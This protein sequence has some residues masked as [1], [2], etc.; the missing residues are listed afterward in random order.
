[1]IAPYQVAVAEQLDRWLQV[2]ASITI[3]ALIALRGVADEHRLREVSLAERLEEVRGFVRDP[4]KFGGHGAMAAGVLLLAATVN[5]VVLWDFLE[6]F[7]WPASITMLADAALVSVE[8][9][10]TAFVGRGIGA[11]V[12][13]RPG[14]FDLERRERQQTLAFTVVFGLVAAGLVLV[15]ALARSSVLWALAGMAGAG[16]GTW[17]GV[18]AYEAKFHIQRD[19]LERKL[20]RQRRKRSKAEE[21]VERAMAFTR[22]TGRWLRDESRRILTRGDQAFVRAYRDEH[23]HEDDVQVPTIPA[24]D[25]VDDDT[26]DRR[27]GLVS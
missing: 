18:A 5:A 26:I 6:G 3:P 7:G 25:L 21:V 23:R 10:L 16:L 11:L 9:V 15:L 24:I 4:L 12:L 22:A 19:W 27:L 20:V 1:M 17:L 14:P 8:V 2:L 13:D